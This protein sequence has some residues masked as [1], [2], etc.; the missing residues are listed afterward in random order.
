MVSGPFIFRIM[1][2]TKKP[3]KSLT[4]EKKWLATSEHIGRNI[5]YC[6]HLCEEY[7]YLWVEQKGFNITPIKR[8]IRRH[9]QLWIKNT[10]GKKVVA[11]IQRLNPAARQHLLE[12]MPIQYRGFFETRDGQFPIEFS[13]PIPFLSMEKKY[14]TT[15]Q[16][17]KTIR[18]RYGRNILEIKNTICTPEDGKVFIA[19]NQIRKHNNVELTDQYTIHFR[20]SFTEIAK[21]LGKTQPY[22]KSTHEGIFHSLERLRSITLTWRNG[23]RFYIG[24]LL[25]SATNLKPDNDHCI[26]ICQ[27][28][29]FS[30]LMLYQFNG[31]KCL[32][33]YYHLPGRLANLFLF[34]NRFQSFNQY[35]TFDSQR[36]HLQIQDIYDLAGLHSPINAP[37]MAYILYDFKKLLKEAKKRKLIK[38]YSMADRHLLIGNEQK[39]RPD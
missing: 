18:K 30:D 23:K 1:E 19:L 7:N 33:F 6:E 35:G 24:G 28:R 5:P 11:T 14:G 32:Q 38:S 12:I 9:V 20:T 37:T 27:D 2:Q 36:W 17:T 34:L 4:E 25:H 39:Q 15:F 31:F 8:D 26:D 10:P 21:E 29:F 13:S 16:I 3:T 22:S